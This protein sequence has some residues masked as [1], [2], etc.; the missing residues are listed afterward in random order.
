MYSLSFSALLVLAAA[1]PSAEGPDAN[2]D[3]EPPPK[4]AKAV[5]VYYSGQ[6]QGVG[7]RATAAEIAK[8]YPVTG[9][10]KNLADGRVQLLA[11][12]SEDGVKKFLAAVRERWKKNIT[13]EE[14]QDQEPTGKWEGFK[15]VE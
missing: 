14:A 12:G 9:W 3:K 8:D 5:M 6:V 15:V 11:E 1:V 4:P 10:V 2:K 7:F 13:K